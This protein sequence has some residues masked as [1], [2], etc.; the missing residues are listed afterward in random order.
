[1]AN[2]SLTFPDGNSRDFDTGITPGA[3]AKKEQ[4]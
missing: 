3:R 2:I 1:M 4:S